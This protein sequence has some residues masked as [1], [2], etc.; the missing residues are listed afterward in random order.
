MNVSFQNLIKNPWAHVV[1]LMLVMTMAFSFSNFSASEDF[2]LYQP[3]AEKIVTEGTVDF[4]I[5]GFH[6]ASF[7]AALVFAVT[8][9]K[10]AIIWVNVILSVLTIPLMF[11]ALR[12]IFQDKMAGILGAYIYLLMPFIYLSS[13]RGFTQASAF[14]FMVL[15]LWLLFKPSKWSW[16]PLSISYVIKPFGIALAPLYLYKKEWRQ[17][18]LSFIIPVIYAGASLLATGGLF[19]G[20][21][22]DINV[23]NLIDPPRFLPNI[24]YAFQNYFSLHNFS[25]INET[26]TLDLVHVSS[27]ISFFALFGIIYFKK[28]FQGRENFF[29]YILATAMFALF[30]PA[31]FT[32]LDMYYLQTFNLVLIILAIPVLLSHKLFWPVAAF[33]FSFQFFYFYLQYERFLV[34]VISVLYLIWAKR[35]KNIINN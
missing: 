15:A 20:V 18:L 11:L 17:L 12:E 23:H 21:H 7:I 14:F 26:Y 27:F 35:N 34:L 30:L 5:P 3:F 19:L 28:Y 16:L 4:T 22:S 24:V 25:P 31:A 6:G 2:H 33:S 29:L 13:L 9:S 1:F 10:F 8:G 32:H